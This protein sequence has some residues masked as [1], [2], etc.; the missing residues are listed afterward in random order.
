[1]ASA[2]HGNL[3]QAPTVSDLSGS[4]GL[5][6]VVN[7]SG[8]CVL[9]GAAV[10]IDGVLVDDPKNGQAGTYQVRDVAKVVAGAAITRGAN[11]TTNA[12]AQFIAATT[13]N[14]IVAK[15]LDAAGA[16]SQ[17]IRAEIGYRGVSA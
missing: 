1:M 5:A 4:T 13:G 14:P 16:A 3:R 10:I 8:Q 7:S 2:Q 12:S 11:L 15:A 6:V 9:A 17:V